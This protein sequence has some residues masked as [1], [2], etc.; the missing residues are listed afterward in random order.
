MICRQLITPNFTN[1]HFRNEIHALI[2]FNHVMVV[3]SIPR[4]SYN[5]FGNHIYNNFNVSN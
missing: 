5:D 2:K 1:Q 4:H 3:G